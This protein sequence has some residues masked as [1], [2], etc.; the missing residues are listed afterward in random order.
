MITAS[1]RAALLALAFT[2]GFSS[3]ALAQTDRKGRPNEFRKPSTKAPAKPTETP[4]AAPD[5]K[6]STEEPKRPGFLT[7][8]P[9]APIESAPLPALDA[10]AA[11]PTLMSEPVSVASIGLSLYLPEGAVV[12]TNSIAGGETKVAIKGPDN[13]WLLQV[14]SSAS[15]DKS[16]TPAKVLD[17]V[18]VQRA[19][20]VPRALPA[21]KLIVMGRDEKLKI[22]E[23]VA[24]RAYVDTPTIPNAVVTGYT[25]MQTA[26]GRF[27]ILQID[28]PRANFATARLTYETVVAAAQFRDPTDM[29]AERKMLVD[30]GE[31]FLQLLS[32]EDF[33]NALDKE[34]NL[35]LRSYIPAPTGAPNDATEVGFQII[36]IRKGQLGE[37]NPSKRREDWNTGE[38]EFGYIVQIDARQLIRDN[39]ADSSTPSAI[40]KSQAIFFLSSDRDRE[41]WSIV[42]ELKRGKKVDR[43]TQTVVRLGKK[44]TAKTE[45]R[46]PEPE[47][48]EWSLPEHGYISRVELQLLPRLMAAK[49]M[50][51]LFGF[52]HY[53]LFTSKLSLRRDEF[54]ASGTGYERLARSAEDA[55]PET[56]VYDAMGRE[57]RRVSTL[58]GVVTEPITVDRL[59][60]LWTDKRLSMD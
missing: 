35:V 12:G 23:Y 9:P 59:K 41:T 4:D 20:L 53:D 51:G 24:A 38:R 18:I 58:N 3:A 16:L 19:Q 60:K 21:H 50:T 47:V 34:G 11:A 57:T 52:Y 30:A 46:T 40:F 10:N 39:P 45:G 29:S 31:A 17:T 43:F 33:D 26:P 49:N 22:S 27:V 8:T 32:T 6:P 7:N 44:L 25:I 55:A 28:M 2:L 56:I 48:G 5:G 14:F 42:N 15:T 54:K 13:A 1:R 37:V 36:S